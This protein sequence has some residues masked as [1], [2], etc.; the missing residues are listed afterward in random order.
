M[1][2]KMVVSDDSYA[3]TDLYF[4]CIRSLRSKLATPKE[5][6]DSAYHQDLQL[7]RC[8]S[9]IYQQI[10]WSPCCWHSLR[11]GC[12]PCIQQSINVSATTLSKIWQLTHQ[13]CDPL[14]SM[15][16]TVE[17]H[18]WLNS[19]T[20]TTIN[21]NTSN[22]IALNGSSSSHNLSIWW[23]C[24]DKIFK[25]LYVVRIR[26]V[27]SEPR[28]IWCEG[29]YLLITTP[30]NTNETYQPLWNKYQRAPLPQ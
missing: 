3:T 12:T 22:W 27:S 24:S 8:N 13:S 17:K 25:E 4:A 15:H 1:L 5:Q 11:E 23:M 9:H 28:S 2:K 7:G 29:W 21:M 16:S 14:S 20:R 18:G 10:L 19:F 6:L 30:D 26:M